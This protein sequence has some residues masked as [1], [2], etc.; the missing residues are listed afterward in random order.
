MIIG[1]EGRSGRGAVDL[2]LKAGVPEQ[3]VVRWDLNE[4]KDR[5]GPYPEIIDSDIFINAVRCCPSASA[6]VSASLETT[7]WECRYISP[8]KFLRSSQETR[9][10]SKVVGLRCCAMW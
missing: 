4:T 7:D 6:S 5:D 2:L 9:P 3:N 1:A 8:A 10:T